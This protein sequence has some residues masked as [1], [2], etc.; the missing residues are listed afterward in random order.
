[1]CIYIYIYTYFGHHKKYYLNLLVSNINNETSYFLFIR[2][3]G[4]PL[5]IED[6]E[7]NDF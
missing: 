5:V 6:F 4:N 1:M 2:T 3:I 7:K